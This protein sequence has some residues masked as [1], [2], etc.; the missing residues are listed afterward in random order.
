[1]LRTNKEARKLY[2]DCTLGGKSH[3]NLL[4]KIVFAP[5]IGFIFCFWF[6]LDFLFEKR[7]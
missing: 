2:W 3:M 1:M 4:G 7:E 5:L 6:I